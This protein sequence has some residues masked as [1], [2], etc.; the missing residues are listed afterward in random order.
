[1]PI[2]G[3]PSGSEPIDI[4]KLLRDL[5]S[6]P[7]YQYNS[8][9]LYPEALGKKL[10]IV[11]VDTRPWNV[12]EGWSEA[13]DSQLYWP[14]MHHYIYASIHG[15]DYRYIHADK[16][17]DGRMDG[18]VK[19][20]TIRNILQEGYE[21]VVYIDYDI[22]FNNMKLPLEHLMS[23]WNV[24]SAIALAGALDPD[25]SYNLD[26]RG[27]LSINTGFLI[28][29]N[30]ARA[31]QM[32][33]AWDECPDLPECKRYLFEWYHDQSAFNSFVRWGNEDVVR[34]I[35]CSEANGASF[36]LNGDNQG[37]IGT[38]ISHYWVD[39]GTVDLAAKAALAEIIMPAAFERLQSEWSN[40]TH[41]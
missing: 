39:K 4:F 23:R 1:M 13:E 3:Q 21:F 41:P 12:D 19:P 24:T 35:P 40:I 29:Q 18:W 6:I 16:F 9:S 36:F 25:R 11:E 17:P 22:I 5:P 38:F 20:S 33:Q 14:R 7:S 15:Y 2:D 26:L 28:W 10:C 34:E 31:D 27:R 8:S 30:T 32:L 37:C